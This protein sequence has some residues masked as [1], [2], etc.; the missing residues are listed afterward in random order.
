MKKL[1]SFKWINII[2]LLVAAVILATGFTVAYFADR[3][4]HEMQFTTDTFEKDG[5]LLTRVAP[6]DPFIAGEDIEITLYETNDKNEAIESII[7][8]SVEWVSPDPSKKIF[9][10]A[11]AESNATITISRSDLGVAQPISYTVIG[12]HTIAFAL[13][14]H[15]L[16]ADTVNGKTV[17]SFHIP[18]SLVS[19]GKLNYS[20]DHVSLFQSPT[21]FS[22]EF[23]PDATLDFGVRVGWA[24]SSIANQNGKA[25][26]GFLSKKDSSGFYSID[27]EFA[28]GY[29]ES[30]MKDFSAK[31]EAKWSHY[32][33]VVNQLNFVEG[34]TSIGDYAFPDFIHVTS[35]RLPE[36]TVSIGTYAFDNIS[37][38]ALT[39]P[40]KTVSFESMSFG[41]I[42]E[43]TEITFNAAEDAEMFFPVAGSTTGAFYVDPYVPTKILGLNATAQNYDWVTDQRRVIPVI[44][45]YDYTYEYNN[46]GEYTAEQVDFHAD[47]YRNTVLNATFADANTY[48]NSTHFS[49][50]SSMRAAGT[51]EDLSGTTLYWDVSDAQDYTVIA[52]L[53]S[54]TGELTIMADGGKVYANENSNFLFG[55]FENVDIIDARKYDTRLATTMGGW[56]VFNNPPP[57]EAGEP[58]GEE[59][60]MPMMGASRV[61]GTETWDMSTV[62]RITDMF[63][64]AKNIEE[65]DV[66]T[67]DTGRLVYANGAF[68]GCGKLK[69][70]DVSN[71]D[72]AD[73]VTLQATFARCDGLESLP[74]ENWDVRSLIDM[75]MTFANVSVETMDLSGWNTTSLEYLGQTFQNCTIKNLNLSG[76]DT[77]H[78]YSL[79]HTFRDAKEL[80][81]L[82]L[83]TWDISAVESAFHCFSG[84]GIKTINLTGWNFASCSDID[85]MFFDCTNLEEIIGEETWTNTKTWDTFGSVFQNCEKLKSLD[86]G[87]WD[88]SGVV[89]ERYGFSYAFKNCKSLTSLDVANWNVSKSKTFRAM[90]MNCE[91]LRSIDISKWDMSGMTYTSYGSDMF[92]GCR[93]LTEL[94]FPAAVNYLVSGMAAYCP[95]LRTVTFLSTSETV[96]SV[97]APGYTN[98]V[99]I[100]AFYVPAEEAL[101]LYPATGKIPT[102][103]I[104]HGEGMANL[105]NG[106]YEFGVDNRD[107]GFNLPMLR[108]NGTW[109]KGSITR[110]NITTVTFSNSTA[111]TSYDECWDASVTNDGAVMAYRSGTDLYIV[112]NGTGK[113]YT[114]PDS[115]YAFGSSYTSS[116][117]SSL[118]SI[119]GMD[120]LDTSYTY[121]M[122]YLFYNMSKVTNLDVSRFNTAKVK[123]MGYMFYNCS[124]LES[125]DLTGWSTPKLTNDTSM[126][127]GCSKLQSMV[128]G[129]GITD[130]VQFQPRNLSSL[131]K[132]TFLHGAEDVV[133][134]PTA[135]SSNG[136][137]YV[138]STVST[139]VCTN[140]TLLKGYTWSTDKRTVKFT[141]PMTVFALVFDPES[142]SVDG[143]AVNS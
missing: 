47:A 7:T 23:D 97:Y 10:N 8:M 85:Y 57:P 58:T 44:R 54:S 79:Y 72:M 34:I 1:L 121:N 61:L 101:A 45:S 98:D 32:K 125:L 42:N 29:T 62:T 136:A 78:V 48:Y 129:A 100:G 127:G 106:E 28:F 122:S 124:A 37:I 18:N 131:T 17:L 141:E 82:D 27:Y 90:F 103:V 135:G 50:I 63:H 55:L 16:R 93:S 73:V 46:F 105:V 94:T 31:T 65:L 49:A 117:W 86:C 20:F 87:G 133:T 19:T 51:H 112:G 13:P 41:H 109:Y 119:T 76:W 67:W 104:T 88:V 25:L 3:E 40:A 130:F 24:A 56:H 116:C 4:L 43:L 91:N 126:F 113:I 60:I 142:G 123:N 120:L 66:S 15:L 134:L 64:N 107:T 96:G 38:S 52:A 83:S 132:I 22:T 75:D 53:D 102:T 137:F 14:A 33:D 140:N 128:I 99:N 92:S 118:T 30:P 9:G 111:P 35:L 114:N 69:T 2:A 110:N 12:D 139:E 21:G 70:L 39:L 95:N 5:Y 74:I 143:Y 11:A 77:S 81:S 68:T 84:S 115:S 71:W 80:T 89:G 36:S 59:I 138:S 6:T 108:S 26:M